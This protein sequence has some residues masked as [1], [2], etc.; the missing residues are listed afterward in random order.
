MIVARRASEATVVFSKYL[1]KIGNPKVASPK[2][3]RVDE[4]G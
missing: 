4:L 3:R 1:T 2:M